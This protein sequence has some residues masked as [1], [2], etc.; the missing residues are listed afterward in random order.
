MAAQANSFQ[1]GNSSAP[2]PA[3][4]SPE[5]SFKELSSPDG[6]RTTSRDGANTSPSQVRGPP[7]PTNSTSP[8][9][10]PG[11]ANRTR[12]NSNKFLQRLTSRNS[13]FDDGEDSQ[14]SA[15]GDQPGSPGS[16]RE[17]KIDMAALSKRRGKY[18]SGINWDSAQFAR[19]MSESIE[20]YMEMGNADSEAL[21][22]EMDETQ[23][24]LN[25]GSTAA[26]KAYYSSLNSTY[27]NTMF[28]AQ[29]RAAMDAH[30][31]AAAAE[32]AAAR[33]AY[34][35]AQAPYEPQQ[36]TTAGSPQSSGSSQSVK[37]NSGD[38]LSSLQTAAQNLSAGPSSQPPLQ[39]VR[40]NPGL[41]TSQEPLPVGDR[42]AQ[43]S[44]DAAV[45]VNA[46]TKSNSLDVSDRQATSPSNA[47]VHSKR[48]TFLGLGSKST[49]KVY[50]IGKKSRRSSLTSTQEDP[51][52][53][54]D[55]EP[56]SRRRRFQDTRELNLLA[57]ELARDAAI[58]ALGQPQ[59]GYA[60][61]S[62]T[63]S[64]S[65]S[66]TPA[67]RRLPSQ[68]GATP[69]VPNLPQAQAPVSQLSPP[70]SAN[71][72]TTSVPNTFVPP[73]ARDQWR[74]GSP[75]GSS[76]GSPRSLTAD[77]LPGTLTPQHRKP[78]SLTPS[79]TQ[80]A[81]VKG[82]PHDMLT[83]LG[84]GPYPMVTAPTDE[85]GGPPS[86]YQSGYSTPRRSR[87]GSASGPSASSVS[88][89]KRGVLSMKLHDPETESQGLIAKPKSARST[90]FGS[91][92]PS[93]NVTP[94]SS[95]TKL[96][97]TLPA[98][99]QTREQT[100]SSSP[101]VGGFFASRRR[102]QGEGENSAPTAPAMA[103]LPTPVMEVSQA[104]EDGVDKTP[105]PTPRH[106][107][108]R[109]VA[110]PAPSKAPAV[111]PQPQEQ[112]TLPNGQT[113]LSLAKPQLST[114]LS[115]P[116]TPG[117]EKVRKSFLGFALGSSDDK[118]ASKTPSAAGATSENAAVQ[119]ASGT[120]SARSSSQAANRDGTQT[121]RSPASRD[122]QGTALN[123]T[124]DEDENLPRYPTSGGTPRRNGANSNGGR[125][126][127]ED[128]VPAAAIGSGTPT[129][130]DQ[131]GRSSSMGYKM[132]ASPF[133]KQAPRSASSAQPT[134]S[135]KR[136]GNIRRLFTRIS[137]SG[138]VPKGSSA[139]KE[140]APPVP[141]S[142][143]P[144]KAPTPS[145]Q[146]SQPHASSASPA[147]PTS[148]PVP[149][150]NGRPLSNQDNR[151]GGMFFAVD[152]TTFDAARPSNDSRDPSSQR[153]SINSRSRRPSL[154][155]DQQGKQSPTSYLDRSSA[156]SALD[157]EDFKADRTAQNGVGRNGASPTTV[158]LAI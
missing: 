124:M 118:K 9:K 17:G 52:S 123:R 108:D 63:P 158:P 157:N 15:Y 47:S 69:A 113:A 107:V 146:R 83:G 35:P 130:S 32:A 20:P 117:K 153:P 145:N 112:K 148:G 67:D 51:T 131:S 94:K 14:S 129:R 105:G 102:S 24:M 150:H 151:R 19:P 92:A 103:P 73:F 96:S 29:Q 27:T 44:D 21:E 66:R 81:Q 68:N 141:A 56:G 42:G 6:A 11:M 5:E 109:Q 142:A 16:P 33:L 36:Q 70:P 57:A 58:E 122:M 71:A 23:M 134:T 86:G 116:S 49:D 137:S 82:L 154:T 133:S 144:S 8:F 125:E 50:K 13:I 99:S 7:S 53:E 140:E 37:N 64:M 93:R 25:S 89:P 90:P 31:R 85:E 95:M 77:N 22:E 111:S 45:P 88:G 121:E 39:G 91:R 1:N 61:W 59:P 114:K 28:P 147:N 143:S 135:P 75:A 104:Q 48:R 30:Q 78:S 120:P 40:S 43:L 155:L 34:L 2:T 3:F 98:P 139:K 62:Q 54:G 106:E 46:K 10:R 115:G 127:S 41:N 76:P 156:G 84:D 18:K 138:K 100:S 79:I 119:V 26:A 149:R 12:T 38:L 74:A 72:S 4:Y 152:D 55:A 80:D 97:D 60:A 126:T 65:G 128:Y 110:M 87:V 132:P 101:S 136:P